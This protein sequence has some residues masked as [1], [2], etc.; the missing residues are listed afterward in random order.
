MDCTY[1]GWWG[2]AGG[3]G[4]GWEAGGGLY[5]PI[6]LFGVAMSPKSARHRLEKPGGPMK[7]L[8][9]TGVNIRPIPP[10]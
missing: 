3:G 1:K 7:R 2:Q 10:I 5:H 6:G 8:T 4:G 9:N